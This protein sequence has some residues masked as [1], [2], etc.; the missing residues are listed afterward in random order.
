[1]GVRGIAWA[2]LVEPRNPLLWVVLNEGTL[3]GSPNE[4]NGQGDKGTLTMNAAYY[5]YIYMYVCRQY[6]GPKSAKTNIAL[7]K[8][9]KCSLPLVHPLI[10]TAVSS[11]HI[12]IAAAAGEAI[13]AKSKKMIQLTRWGS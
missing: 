12:H 1:M 8:K 10:I 2:R 3:F 7:A 9:K 11:G 13:S 6:A 5:M 4:M